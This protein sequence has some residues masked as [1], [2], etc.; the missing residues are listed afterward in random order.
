MMCLPQSLRDNRL[1]SP[2]LKRNGTLW[3]TEAVEVSLKMVDEAD[4]YLGVF[5]HRYGYVPDGHDM[6][7]IEM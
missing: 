1:F 3:P 2:P 5:A 6:S 7:I 4:I